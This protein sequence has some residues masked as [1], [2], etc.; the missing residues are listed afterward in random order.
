M[1]L[2]DRRA[3]I[4]ELKVNPNDLAGERWGLKRLQRLN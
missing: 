4:S 2:R 3:I 1:E